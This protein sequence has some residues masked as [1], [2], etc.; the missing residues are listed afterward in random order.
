MPI[1][2]PDP[3]ILDIRNELTGA[4]VSAALLGAVDFIRQENKPPAFYAGVFAGGAAIAT[5]VPGGAITLYV[6]GDTLDAQVFRTPDSSNLRVFLNGVQYT[7]LETYAATEVWEILQVILEEGL[8]RVDF[9]NDG[10]GVQN[11][12]N[13]SWLALAQFDVQGVT[14]AVILENRR[15]VMAT[16]NASIS[17][18]DSRN[19][20]RAINVRVPDTIAVADVQGYVQALIPLI[21]AIVQVAFVEASLE[22]PIVLPGGARAVPV[23]Q[24]NGDIGG[25]FQFA[26]VGQYPESIRLPGIL[27]TLISGDDILVDGQAD[28]VAFRDAIINGLD[29]G[30]VQVTPSD[31]DGFDFTGLLAASYSNRRK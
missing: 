27:P 24:S 10:P 21:E 12:G 19:R 3:G 14:D 31:R 18:V 11:A 7:S 28:V 25:L 17:T 1:Y 8:N 9:V 30:G 16:Y 23:A 22:V 26:T 13:I 4:L 15:P 6:I 29:V 2:D 20:R 5:G